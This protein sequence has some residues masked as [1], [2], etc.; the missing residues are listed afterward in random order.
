MIGE[1]LEPCDQT[2]EDASAW[3]EI[4]FRLGNRGSLGSVLWTRS[5]MGDRRD[6]D[7]MLAGQD[8]PEKSVY[9]AVRHGRN[10]TWAEAIDLRQGTDRL[11]KHRLPV[12][13]WTLEDSAII[14]RGSTARWA[15]TLRALGLVQDIRDADLMYGLMRS[16]TVF[17]ESAQL[18]IW[19]ACLRADVLRGDWKRI[20]YVTGLR[21]MGFL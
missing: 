3:A 6:A 17:G 12:M 20:E 4:I 5:L 9:L 15:S 14:L 16:R 2:T 1:R 18:G 21:V 13:T 11:M 19:S 8:W 10:V 7:V